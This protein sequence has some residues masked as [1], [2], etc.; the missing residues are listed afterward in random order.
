MKLI[1]PGIAAV[2]LSLAAASSIF[3]KSATE[4]AV[5]QEVETG[6]R[7]LVAQMEALLQTHHFNR[8]ELQGERYDITLAAL[9]ELAE[10]A[11][12]QEAFL[13]GF[14]MVWSDGPFSHVNLMPSD[15]TAAEMSAYFDAM[16]VG[17]EATNLSFVDNIA[18]LS[19]HTMM[20]QDTVRFIENAFSEIVAYDPDALIIDL[21]RNEGGAF[22]MRPTI[23]GVIETPVDAGY[24]I[25]RRWTDHNEHQPTR[26]DITALDTWTGWS[27][28]EF[29]DAIIEQAVIR[30]RFQ[31]SDIVYRGPVYVLTS[32]TT[33]SAAEMAVE[34]L[35]ATG[36]VQVIG[37]PTAGEM[38]SQRPFDLEEGFLLFLPIADY[39]PLHSGR[40]EGHPI[41]P[42]IMV[43]A[44]RALARA[45]ELARE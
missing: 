42:D 44:D 15:H 31:P 22:A 12:D 16:N 38:L 1:N 18:V 10:T 19:V 26:E 36:R 39:Y 3:L 17:P 41:Q 28:R 37:E 23:S 5:E 34:V 20:G 40:I 6:Y 32:E 45:M 27:V 2:V 4:N 9:Y 13:D 24:F 7:P 30:V 8:E 29:W 25:S 33:A 35:Q 21:R 14:R 43:D 11:P